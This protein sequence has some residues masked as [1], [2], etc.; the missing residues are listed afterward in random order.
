MAR[1]QMETT[2]AVLGDGHRYADVVIMTLIVSA[3]WIDNSTG[4]SQEHTDWN[5]GHQMAGPESARQDLWGSGPVK[6]LGAKFLPQLADSDLWVEQTELQEFESEVLM[7]I[8][9]VPKLRTQLGRGDSCALPH[10][11][12]NFMRAI[13]YAKHKG[14]GV[15]IT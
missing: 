6:E 3:H 11:L 5:D 9:A 15:N 7:L 10:Y 14:G 1:L 13:L 4:A 12:N 2:L 8:D